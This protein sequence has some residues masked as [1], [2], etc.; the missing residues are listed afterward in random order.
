MPTIITTKRISILDRL[1][2]NKM[3]FTFE[4]VKIKNKGMKKVHGPLGFTNLDKQGMLIEGFEE[5]PSVASVYH[6]LFCLRGF[7]KQQR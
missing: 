1:E 2:N 4:P 7:R 3:R 5:I 6:A